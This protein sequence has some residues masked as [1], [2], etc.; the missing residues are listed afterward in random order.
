MGHQAQA[1]TSAYI[2]VRKQLRTPIAEG[3]A[4]VA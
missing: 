1:A 2:D 3:D 4:E